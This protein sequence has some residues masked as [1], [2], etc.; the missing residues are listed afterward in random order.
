MRLAAFLLVLAV[1][2]GA[3]LVLRSPADDPSGLSPEAGAAA[4]APDTRVPVDLVRGEASLA[5]RSE[6]APAP[7]PAAPAKSVGKE[8]VK[9][10]ETVA[11]P[12]AIEGIGAIGAV[13]TSET[14]PVMDKKYGGSTPDERR[15]AIQAI[16]D[17]YANSTN[18]DPKLATA[19][20]HEIEWLERSLDG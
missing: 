5:A 10:P 20:K 11:L 17:L 6:I 14:D 2:L 1:A 4:A 7:P 9:Q 13:D 12:A 16:R 19:L 8:T 15:Q 3:F 18:I